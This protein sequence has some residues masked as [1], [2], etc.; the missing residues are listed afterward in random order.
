MR[1]QNFI[2]CACIHAWVTMTMTVSVL[3]VHTSVEVLPYGNDNDN[4]NHKYQHENTDTWH[5]TKDIQIRDNILSSSMRANQKI[6]MPVDIDLLLNRLDYLVKKLHQTNW[7]TGL[8]L[9]KDGSRRHSMHRRDLTSEFK[10]DIGSKPSNGWKN[11]DSKLDNS[12]HQNENSNNYNTSNNNNNNIEIS[13]INSSPTKAVSNDDQNGQNNQNNQK[14]QNFNKK[15]KTK[16]SYQENYNSMIPQS[17]PTWMS[18]NYIKGYSKHPWLVQ[19]VGCPLQWTNETTKALCK[20][21]NRIRAQSYLEDITLLPVQDNSGAL[22]ANVYCA[23][24][25]GIP[26]GEI[27]PWKTSFRCQRNPT[28]HDNRIISLA[29][30]LAKIDLPMPTNCS[31]SIL[32]WQPE[33]LQKCAFMP[34]NFSYFFRSFNRNPYRYLVDLT[35]GRSFPISFNM[36]LNF[37]FSGNTHVLFTAGQEVKFGS[38][39]VM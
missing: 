16:S 21:W 12:R 7:Q 28:S 3:M 2:S 26:L 9:I 14:D 23:I 24:C 18:C 13:N 20:S 34:N 11:K 5:S 30:E 36:L 39:I 19:V 6:V 29:K 4:E 32:P 15:K 25:H 17:Y 8:E 1:M 35:E 38:H 37:D 22:Y 27:H 31:R 33:S 10:P